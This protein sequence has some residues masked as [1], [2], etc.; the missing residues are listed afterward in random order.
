MSLFLPMTSTDLP[1]INS[2][3]TRSPHTTLLETLVQPRV[4]TSATGGTDRSQH[5]LRLRLYRGS[6]SHSQ[7]QPNQQ[8]V[9]RAGARYNLIPRSCSQVSQSY[10][11]PLCPLSL[12][13]APSRPVA[14]HRA[15]Y[16]LGVTN[17]GL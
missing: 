2:V 11:L 16:Y 14:G 10:M 6:F 13:L 7:L 17:A 5:C 9:A 8:Y 15:V 1:G 4:Q 12:Q 3:R